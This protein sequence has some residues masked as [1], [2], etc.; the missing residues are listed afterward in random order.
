MD[1]T[2][3]TRLVLTSSVIRSG[4]KEADLLLAYVNDELL[5]SYPP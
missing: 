3:L 5:L 4:D 2:S 1:Q